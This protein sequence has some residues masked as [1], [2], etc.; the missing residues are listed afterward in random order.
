MGFAYD[1][2]GDSKW[3]AYGSYSQFFDITKLELPRGSFGGDHWIYYYWTLDTYDY[4]T[5]NCDE[6]NTGC[7]GTFLD[8]NGLRATART[9]WTRSSPSTSAGRT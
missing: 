2:K 5:I 9:R 7:P 6:G 4:S 3:K 8:S 1:I